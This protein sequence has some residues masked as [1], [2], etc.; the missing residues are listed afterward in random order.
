MYKIEFYLENV[1]KPVSIVQN[2]D[3]SEIEKFKDYLVTIIKNGKNGF[4][5]FK[6]EDDC[7]FVKINKISSVS[8]VHIKDNILIEEEQESDYESDYNNDFPKDLMFPEDLESTKNIVDSVFIQKNKEINLEE[9]E[10]NDLNN[11]KKF[12]EKKGYKE[13]KHKLTADAINTFMEEE[14]EEETVKQDVSKKRRGRKKI[15]KQV[16]N[17]ENKELKNNAEIKEENENIDSIQQTDIY[18]N[19]YENDYENEK[20]GYDFKEEDDSEDVKKN[21]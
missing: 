8:I 2:M 10:E 18:E 11:F 20:D 6:N 17:K 4:L 14:L 16:Q 3:S 9:T 21:L 1:G 5:M 12:L 15:N 7:I 13:K 19:D